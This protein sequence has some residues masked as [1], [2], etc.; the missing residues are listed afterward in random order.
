MALMATGAADLV[1]AFHIE[2]KNNV[3]V[4]KKSMLELRNYKTNVSCWIG[5][6]YTCIPTTHSFPIS[7]SKYFLPNPVGWSIWY[8]C[9]WR[10]YRLPY[11]TIYCSLYGNLQIFNWCQYCPI[12]GCQSASAWS[13]ESAHL[14]RFPMRQKYVSMITTDPKSSHDSLI[15]PK[16]YIPLMKLYRNI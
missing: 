12:S 7:Y 9:S 14:Y 11:R 10:W 13:C 6:L 3:Q 5:N 15:L 8:V 1:S 16:R 4:P 2:L